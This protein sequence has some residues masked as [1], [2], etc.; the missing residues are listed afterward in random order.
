MKRDSINY[1]VVGLFVVTAAVGMLYVLMRVTGN[2]GPV[3][4]YHVH[5]QNVSGAKFG[6]PVLYEG[7]RIGQVEQIIPQQHNGSLRFK[8]LISVAQDWR[9]PDDSVASL[10]ASGLLGTVALEIKAGKSQTPVAKGSAI[11]PD[12]RI[13]LMASL[14][15]TVKE[16]RGL[17]DEGI[18]P[19]LASVN[20]HVDSLAADLHQIAAVDMRRLIDTATRRVDSPEIFTKIDSLL[21]KLNSSAANLEQLVG[22]QNQARVSGFLDEINEGAKELSELIRRIEST[23]SELNA[24]LR[25]VDGVVKDADTLVTNADGLITENRPNLRAAIAD[26]RKTLSVVAQNIDTIAYNLESSSRNMNEFT[27]QI[28]E[29]PGL[30][31]GSSPQRE[32]SK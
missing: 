16:Y 28:R 25:R 5:Y 1:T 11:S 31:L 26:M 32:R 23:R 14:N 4:S 29:N 15:E 22:A 17:P 30:L 27:R 9:I 7:Y 24:V 18:K 8:L 21:A 13:D 3:D 6:T 10:A 12:E 20:A 2:T 19:L